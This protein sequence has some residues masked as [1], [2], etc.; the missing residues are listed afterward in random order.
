MPNA[1][2]IIVSIE[3]LL[4]IILIFSLYLLSHVI[5]TANKEKLIRIL[6]IGM[7][8]ASSIAAIKEKL[9]KA[10]AIFKIVRVNIIMSS[11]IVIISLISILCLIKMKY[12]YVPLPEDIIVTSILGIIPLSPAIILFEQFIKKILAVTVLMAKN[13]ESKP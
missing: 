11:I 9:S 4:F 13:E 3:W 6:S 5:K 2:E 1:I 7:K 10:V 12:V 8:E